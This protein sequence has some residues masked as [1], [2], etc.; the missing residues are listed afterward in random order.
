MESLYSVLRSLENLEKSGNSCFFREF[1]QT[2][3]VF[4]PSLYAQMPNNVPGPSKTAGE[5]VKKVREF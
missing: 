5:N 2:L 4:A 3:I 1:S